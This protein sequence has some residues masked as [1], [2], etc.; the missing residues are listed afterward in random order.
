MKTIK[1]I[2]TTALL[3][4][5]S[6][7]TTTETYAQMSD[8]KFNQLFE[9]GFELALEGEYEKAVQI[10]N[11]LAEADKNHAQ[12]LYLQSICKK[13]VGVPASYTVNSLEKAV[14]NVDQFHQ[15]GRVEDK[16]A[17]VKAWF[18]LGEAQADAGNYDRAIEAY[19]NYMS[20]IPLA[21]LD[22]KREVI[23]R[24]KD[25]KNQKMTDQEVGLSSTLA[26]KQP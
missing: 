23:A 16:S 22:H 24:I 9:I 11:Q 2:I 7:A 8:Y 14:K 10:F 17:P 18:H 5:L 25:L 21:S 12:V 26:R 6:L 13:K 15:T 19:R 4:T 3:G 1:I 20:C